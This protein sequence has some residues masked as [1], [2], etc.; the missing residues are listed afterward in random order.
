M[1]NEK[2]NKPTLKVFVGGI[3]LSLN[4]EDLRPI[5]AEFGNVEYIH[6]NKC[7]R[8]NSKGFGFV[9][10]ET[11]AMAI[12]AVNSGLEL[13]GKLLD[14]TFTLNKNRIKK[15]KRTEPYRKAHFQKCSA[16]TTKQELIEFFG[17]FGEVDKVVIS[18]STQKPNVEKKGYII[19]KV[20]DG[21][22]SFKKLIKQEMV[23][24]AK[25]YPELQNS[26]KFKNFEKKFLG[27]F[28]YIENLR[29]MEIFI[30]KEINGQKKA[31]LIPIKK[32]EEVFKIVEQYPHSSKNGKKIEKI[33]QK[34]GKEKKNVQKNFKKCL[35]KKSQ[36]RVLVEK[37]EKIKISTSFVKTASTQ[38]KRRST[39]NILFYELGSFSR[40]NTQQE[41]LETPEIR[42]KLH[43]ITNKYRSNNLVLLQGPNGSYFYN[44]PTETCSSSNPHYLSFE[45][46][47]IIM[48]FENENLR[49]RFWN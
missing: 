45:R 49:F 7:K 14:I 20:D 28:F 15:L 42:R 8:G 17:Q 1:E 40:L 36:N 33:K 37:K 22:T 2:N 5:F 47:L 48:N 41:K 19:Y 4:E 39:K 29:S 3:P 11:F 27:D 43:K 46:N 44:K 34:N 31:E 23:K 16:S 32:W 35:K 24:I 26:P 6:L 38:K 10:F 12:L 13:Q 18:L 25:N 9:K 21:F 30:E